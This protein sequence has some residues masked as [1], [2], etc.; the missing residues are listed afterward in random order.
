MADEVVLGTGADVLLVA[1]VL[2]TGADVLVTG[3]DVLAT[4]ADV[5]A[6]GAL[7]AAKVEEA[8]VFNSVSV[9]SS[10]SPR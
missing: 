5:L 7:V 3:T 8:R 9:S 10:K 4:G 1:D 6:T 2:A